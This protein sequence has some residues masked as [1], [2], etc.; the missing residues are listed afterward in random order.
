VTEPSVP[1]RPTVPAE[2][3]AV[4]ADGHDDRNGRNGRRRARPAGDDGPSVRRARRVGDPPSVRRAAGPAGGLDYLTTR[5]REV[6]EL[7][8]NGLSGDQVGHVLGISANTV[9]THVQNLMRKLGVRSRLEAVSLAHRAGLVGL[10]PARPAAAAPGA[11]GAS[12]P[13]AAPARP[14]V[15]VTEPAAMAGLLQDMIQR[16]REQDAVYGR[17]STLSNRERQVFALLAEGYDH[18]RIADALFLSPHTSRTH[19][20][21]VLA[22]LGVHSR[23]EAAALAIRYNLLDAPAWV[24]DG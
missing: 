20:Q 5:E 7:V 22:K 10:A 9:R 17:W 15:T 3:P 14:R 24:A 6:L 2:G 19:I 11:P 23:V 4:A 12:A 8:A 13:R 21:N 16:R 1:A 18:R